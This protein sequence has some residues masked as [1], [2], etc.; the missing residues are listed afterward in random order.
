MDWSY[1]SGEI[2]VPLRSPDKLLTLSNLLEKFPLI[3]FPSRT[4]WC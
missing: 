1:I 4:S 3:E 2:E